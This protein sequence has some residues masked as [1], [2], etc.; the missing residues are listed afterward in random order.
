M[1]KANTRL[2]ENCE[3][4]QIRFTSTKAS[5]R[6]KEVA[7]SFVATLPFQIGLLIICAVADFAGF[8]QMFS[9]T[10]Y[11]AVYT[12][13]L[14]IIGMLIGF[15]VLP[16]LCANSAKKINQKLPAKKWLPIAY[17]LGFLLAVTLNLYLRY[18]TRDTVFPYTDN[19]STSTFGTVQTEQLLNPN[20]LPFSIFFGIV[21][22]LTS[23]ISFGCA[24][25]LFDPL[26]NKLIPLEAERE[27]ILEEM[28]PFTTTLEEYDSEEDRLQRMHDGN[29]RR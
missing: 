21:P 24:Y 3:D 14:A 26:K 4:G 20:A 29:D 17:G 16:I 15:E 5:R 28:N 13:I 12:Q 19:F 11:D 10:L 22:V 6:G 25:S 1:D 8:Y 7:E 18:T 9:L 2:Y 23:I 27:K